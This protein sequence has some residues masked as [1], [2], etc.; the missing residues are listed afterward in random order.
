MPKGP[1]PNA[2]RRIAA[3]AKTSD[4]E[5]TPK[6]RVDLR[7]ALL[8]WFDVAARTLPWRERRDAYGIWLSEIMLQQTRVD[9][10]IP[11]YERFLT[12]Y[13]TVHALADAPV[14]DVLKQWAGLGYYR[15]ARQL[16]Q[17]AREVV[18]NH[19][20]KF[21]QD[22]K[23]LQEL[24]GVGRYT[25]GAIASIAFGVAT[26]LVDGNVIRV[27]ARLF[28]L[29]EDMRKS[30]GVK[31]VWRL[32]AELVDSERP[33]DFNQSL[34]EL[35]ATVCTPKAPRCA[36]CPVAADCAAKRTGNPLALPVLSKRAKPKV[37]MAAS[38]VWRG[39]D[40]K[41]LLA[42]RNSEGLFGGMWE[43]PMV[44]GTRAMLPQALRSLQ[45]P[46]DSAR[47]VGRVRHT[48]SHRRYE[49]EVYLV[50]GADALDVVP[51][52]RFA[53]PSKYDRLEF[54]SVEDAPLSTFAKKVL[55]A[56]QTLD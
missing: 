10:V 50:D 17:A 32:A 25:A 41:T 54:R 24:S 48:L 34:M 36:D 56:T 51:P 2:A 7:R 15:R 3:K 18:A 26:P 39:R 22:P 52:A 4:P 46:V 30:A 19:E 6:Q 5:L 1:N 21:P 20:G 33:G 47:V 11:Y 8:G 55:R 23:G 14:E 42:R 45:L 40:G 9:T 31:R 12:M 49:V 37:V 13:P 43:P 27:F 16:C 38:L 35:G 53:D 28:G 44:E 29:T